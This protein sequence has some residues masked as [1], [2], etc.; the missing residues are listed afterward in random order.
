MEMTLSRKVLNIAGI[1]DYIAGGFTLL[2]GA[3]VIGA[4]VLAKNDPALAQD[5]PVDFGEHTVLIVGITLAAGAIFTLVYA[6]L[7]RVAAKNPA[8]IMPVWVLSILSVGFS[9]F[10]L[11]S[12]LTRHAA[13]ADMGPNFAG[14]VFGILMLVI[15]N[16]IK[17]E[18]GR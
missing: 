13:L 16:N 17:K 12:D 1:L 10:T 14:L 15:A 9:V 3:V 18:A 4:D 8:K 5:M 7:E 2:L 6:H 11:I